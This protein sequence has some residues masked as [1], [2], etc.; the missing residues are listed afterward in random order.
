MLRSPVCFPSS[1]PSPSTHTPL[2][3][4]IEK[5]NFILNTATTSIKRL[6]SIM[7]S[8]G[9][10]EGVQIHKSEIGLNAGPFYSPK[11][12]ERPHPTLPLKR[13]DRPLYRSPR[14]SRQYSVLWKAVFSVC[15]TR[16]S[17]VCDFPGQCCLP[18]SVLK[19]EN[20]YTEAAKH[21]QIVLERCGDGEQKGI[22][23][24]AP[25]FGNQ[26][27]IVHIC[28]ACACLSVSPDSV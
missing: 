3:M 1:T 12:P 25:K 4:T 10:K 21:V 8:R 26:C 2:E 6:L 27:S 9:L 22:T 16:W 18:L 28:P 24:S 7:Y 11:K 5:S 20:P 19:T 17:R 13:Q 15:W 23:K 14:I